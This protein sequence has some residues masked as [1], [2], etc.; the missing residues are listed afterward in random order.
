VKSSKRLNSSGLSAGAFA[1]F[2]AALSH[3]N[4]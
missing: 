3:N 2:M 4:P 1:F